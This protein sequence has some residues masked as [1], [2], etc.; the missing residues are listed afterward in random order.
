[1][2]IKLSFM[3]TNR[4]FIFSILLYSACLQLSC[5]INKDK[6]SSMDS[7]CFPI[8]ESFFEKIKTSNFRSALNDLLNSNPNINPNDSSTIK[9]KEEF[10]TLN[11]I[12]GNYIG[13]R[14]FKK[15][16]IVDD[17]AIYSYIVKYEKKFYRF[18][19]VFYNASNNN[20][21]IYKFSLDETAELE[22][23]ESLKLYID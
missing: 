20:V 7:A 19:F 3:T 17:I 1:M 6:S 18:V 12:S 2:E 23:E 14:L 11:E 5:T 15:R 4:K 8:I 22:L 9:L 13:Y 10:K 21:K 16:T